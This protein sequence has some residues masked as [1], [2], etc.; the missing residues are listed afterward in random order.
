VV[1]P[2]LLLTRNAG[3]RPKH[4]PYQ[5]RPKPTG[6]TRF[7]SQLCAEASVDQAERQ[8]QI[9]IAHNW[10]LEWHFAEKLASE[11]YALVF[12]GLPNAKM[13]KVLFDPPLQKP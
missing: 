13:I 8:A 3:C 2:L 11:Y 12:A 6:E 1:G 9:A 4:V 7:S 10:K 5:G